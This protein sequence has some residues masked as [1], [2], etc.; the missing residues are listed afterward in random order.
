MDQLYVPKVPVPLHWRD[1]T[2]TL[3][4]GAR[5]KWLGILGGRSDAWK[6]QPIAGHA[7]ERTISRPVAGHIPQSQPA[8]LPPFDNAAEYLD[9]IK[10][11]RG[12]A[13][14][15]M[16]ALVQEL[17]IRLGHAPSA[18]VFRVGFVDVAVMGSNGKPR[19]VIEVKSSLRSKTDRDSALRQA[20]DYANRNGATLVV[21]TDA[22]AYEIYD[23]TKGMDHASQLQ[24][25]FRLS[26]FREMDA[27][28]LN[29][30]KP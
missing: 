6:P 3:I 20:F 11:A 24:A 12:L 14:R 1:Y 21:I 9:R 30:L 13:E 2:T 18:V 19:I 10:S 16:E 15:N 22:D 7:T 27:A 8:V 17:L 25:N 23:R 26:A 28:G 4:D 5:E 29:L